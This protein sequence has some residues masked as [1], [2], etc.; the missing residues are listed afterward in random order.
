M[1]DDASADDKT[2]SSSSTDSD[3]DQMQVD[4]SSQDAELVM[5][6]EAELQKNPNAYDTHVQVRC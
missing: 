4:V 2:T 3:D 1:A 5:G 6:L